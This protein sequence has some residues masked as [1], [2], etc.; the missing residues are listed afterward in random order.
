MKRKVTAQFAPLAQPG[1]DAVP[2]DI[3]IFPPSPAVPVDGRG[4][5][6]Y[7]PDT[8]LAAFDAMGGPVP[9]DY[10]HQLDDGQV[11]SGP[12]PAAGDYLSMRY[13]PATGMRATVA[14]T[15]TCASLIRERAYRRFS[16]AFEV[17]PDDPKNPDG[18]GEVVAIFGGSVVQ[19]PAFGT[20]LQF[21]SQQVDSPVDTP[22][23]TQGT[24]PN[25]EPIS[26]KEL[27]A[28][29][30]LAET[31]SEADA[32][33]AVSALQ[34][35]AAEVT[36]V[37]TELAAEAATS[38]AI[39]TAAQKKFTV[40]MT[41]YVAKTAHDAVVAELAS[42]KSANADAAIEA[43]IKSTESTGV[44]LTVEQ[45]AAFKAIGQTSL[46]T[47]KTALAALK[48]Q[49]RAEAKDP[50]KVVTASA[51][52]KTFGLTPEQQADARRAGV[53]FKARAAALAKAA[54]RTGKA[55]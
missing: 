7:D 42:L 36:A 53:S 16:P 26:M 1:S 22:V 37:A 29:L 21:A 2:T 46:A 35:S 52:D 6:R 23:A 31:A 4:P 14:W 39:V 32:I 12:V 40:D 11:R 5:W 45:R 55:A 9:L 3:C 49:I 27:F 48:P 43:E 24:K 25:S 38:A 34:A 19:R 50:T 20:A 8:L 15:D 44:T 54:A 28:K 41:A 10:E 51:D 33:A 18:P 17:I 13:D 30:G 47:L